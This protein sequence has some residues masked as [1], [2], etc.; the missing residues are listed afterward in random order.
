[1]PSITVDSLF[2][3]VLKEALLLSAGI[4]AVVSSA[5]LLLILVRTGQPM[6]PRSFADLIARMPPDSIAAARPESCCGVCTTPSIASARFNLTPTS[7][8]Y[9]ALRRS[10]RP[11]IAP[12]PVSLQR[13]A[14][15]C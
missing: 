2:Y 4:I 9:S 15:S 11:L 5:A 13:L 7:L 14:A 6:L 8:L 12:W 1:M 3:S 10:S